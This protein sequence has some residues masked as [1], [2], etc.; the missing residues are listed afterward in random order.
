M[1]RTMSDVAPFVT[2]DQGLATVSFA[3]PDGTV[4]SSVINAGVM[5]H[6]VDGHD[7]VAFV[8]RGNAHK[9]RHWREH[10]AA[11]IVFRAGW[12]WI[13]VEGSITV[14][15]PDDPTDDVGP[16]RLPELLRAVFSAAGGTH[17]DWDT[18]DRVMREERRTAVFIHPTRIRGN[19]SVG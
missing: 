14:I 10:P 4:H 19:G 16:D 7:V 2:A 15:G 1:E 11:T 9:L 6:P 8:V 17:D 5:P 3:R 12:A 13:G 18:Y